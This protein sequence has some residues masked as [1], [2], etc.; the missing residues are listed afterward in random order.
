MKKQTAEAHD[1]IT[2]PQGSACVLLQ[3]WAD[4]VGTIPPGHWDA[5]AAEDFIT[6][7]FSEIRWARNMALLNMAVMDAG[8]GVLNT[9]IF[10]ITQ[11]QHQ[12]D[13]SIKTLTGY[14]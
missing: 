2:T 5:I 8:I 13:P 3:F 6:Q 12:M 4:G 7:N 11:G 9:K 10:T 1:L 14:T